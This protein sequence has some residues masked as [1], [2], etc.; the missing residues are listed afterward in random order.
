MLSLAEWLLT[1]NAFG[2][3]YIV[4]VDPMS[5]FRK[6]KVSRCTYLQDYVMSFQNVHSMFDF[7]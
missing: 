4:I 1:F 2:S 6:A 3:R 5:E 7:R